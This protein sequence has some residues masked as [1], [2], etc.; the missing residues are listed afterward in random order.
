MSKF[1][2]FFLALVST[3]CSLNP[4]RHTA[5]D[6]DAPGFSTS[7]ASELY[8]KN[9]RSNYY[10]K[11]V[12]DAAKLD[13]YRSKNWFMPAGKPALSLQIV[14]NWRYDEAYML[15]T[16]NDNWKSFE[17]T[18]IVWQDT[19][20]DTSGTYPAEIGNK[21]EQFTLA[22]RLYNSI[23]AEHE[24]YLKNKAGKEISFLANYKYREAFRKTMIDYFRL[25][26][27]L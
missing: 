5:I 3:A 26:D 7:D 10:N 19:T 13:V 14:V 8:F 9:V 2:L 23:L 4:D 6:L 21:E 27:R 17:V 25:V 22:G 1:Y 11:T 15:T 18:S 24:L 12:N 20:L 16:P